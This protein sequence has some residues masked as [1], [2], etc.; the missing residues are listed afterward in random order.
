MKAKHLLAALVLPAVFT[1]CSQE[2]LTTNVEKEVVGTPIGYLEF[3]ASKGGPTTRLSAVTKDWEAEDKIGLGWISGGADLLASTN[4]FSNHPLY[5][6]SDKRNF[7][8]ETMVYEGLYIAS[9]PFQKTQKIAPLEFNLSKQKSE[10]SYYS[11][12]WHVS[13]KFFTLDEESAG[14]GNATALKLVPLTNLMQLNIKLKENAKVPED[15]KV[16]GVTLD[17]GRNGKLVNKLKFVSNNVAVLDKASSLAVAAWEGTTGNIDVQVGEDK[18]GSA[19]DAKDGLNVYVQMGAFDDADATTLVI[20]TNYG[21]V[22]I[23]SGE[24]SVSWSSKDLGQVEATKVATFA[25]AIKTMQVKATATGK[26][27]GQNVAV[28]VTLDEASIEVNNVVTN[29]A[30]LEAYVSALKT[31]GKLKDNAT[32]QFGLSGLKG[33]DQGIKSDN[34]VVI[35]DISVVNAIEG[36]ITFKKDLA[37]PTNVYI[38]GELALVKAPT[39]NSVNFQI[40]NGQTLTV[41]KN[42]DLGANKFEVNA[43]ATL[44]NKAKISASGSDGG[45]TTAAKV[46]KTAKTPALPAG[47]YISEEGASVEL[48][49]S[50]TFTNEGAVEWKGGALPADMGGVIYANVA[51]AIDIVNA[52]KAFATVTGNS[53]SAATKEV[54][55]ANDLSTATQL[56]ETTIA[57]VKKMTIKGNVT[58]GLGMEKAF[59]FSDLAEIDVESGSFNLTGGN[60]GKGEDDFYA[61]ATAS[62]CK[63]N[64]ASGTELSVAAGTKL[65]LSASGAVYYTGATVTNYGYIVGN[66]A[67]GSGTWTGN[68]INVNPKAAK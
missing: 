3:T 39:V 7:K 68:A 48:T 11:L 33:G 13:D 22:E 41:A 4:L 8:S 58:F 51:T 62:G 16:T 35:T 53:P 14:L 44:V 40:L 17:D 24:K 50:A 29:Q 5:Y 46:E 31:L 57:G 38:A 56:T 30:E 23:V 34:D 32:I 37:G 61:F 59:T 6:K 55:I 63:V 60:A 45:I 67:S 66:S 25:D 1:A 27:Y 21:D 36:A 64:L 9:F 20:H 19:I 12:R 18:V 49:S 2:E 26:E 52:G 65:D 47:L 42:F 54:I 28:N 15:F 10:D 43:G